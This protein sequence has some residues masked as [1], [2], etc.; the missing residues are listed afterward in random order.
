MSRG[1]SLAVHAVRMEEI[2]NALKCCSDSVKWTDH[3]EE[4]RID[5]KVILKRIL[6]IQAPMDGSYVHD[7]EPSGFTKRGELFD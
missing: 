1:V 4:L 7:N 3:V 2:T 5:G 6:K